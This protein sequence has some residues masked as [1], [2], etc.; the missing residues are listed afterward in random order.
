MELKKLKAQLA[1]TQEALATLIAW[2]ALSKA[3]THEQ[4][5]DLIEILHGPKPRR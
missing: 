2:T 3:I 1:Q 4:G 5:K